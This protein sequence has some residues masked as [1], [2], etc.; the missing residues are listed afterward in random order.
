MKFYADATEVFMGS[1]I[2]GFYMRAQRRK[3][4]HDIESA[5]KRYFTCHLHLEHKLSEVLNK[6]CELVERE[7]FTE[8]FSQG[9]LN[10]YIEHMQGE[11]FSIEFKFESNSR[12]QNL[13]ALQQT[14]RLSLNETIATLFGG[15][16]DIEI[17]VTL[18]EKN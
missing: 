5:N 16:S 13:P 6:Q 10:A 17:E 14:V 1:P 2:G 7:W 9:V 15:E 12:A 3:L 11:L 18:T 4:A 8:S